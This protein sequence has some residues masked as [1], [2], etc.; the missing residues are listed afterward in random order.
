MN[1]IKEALDEFE[2]SIRICCGR[3]AKQADFDAMAAARERVV[4]LSH[5]SGEPVAWAVRNRLNP[6]EKAVHIDYPSFAV[7]DSDLTIIPLYAALPDRDAIIEQCAKVA[8]RSKAFKV[9]DDI[10]SLKQQPSQDADKR[11]AP[12]QIDLDKDEAITLASFISAEERPVSLIVSDG[13]AGFGLYA[14]D[15]EYPDEP[16]EFI[17]AIDQAIA[18]EGEKV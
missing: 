11:D 3:F 4:A 7:G 15:T 12:F 13:R 14:F 6:K 1:Q 8:A 18:N 9:A 10:R 16:A 17:A 2:R 5:L